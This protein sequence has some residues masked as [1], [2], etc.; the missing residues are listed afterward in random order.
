MKMMKNISILTGAFVMAL[1][2]NSSFAAD[3]P[4]KQMK[5]AIVNVQEVLQKSP[6]VTALSKKLESEFK[7][8]QT[9]INDEQKS[10]QDS[11]EKIKKDAATMSQK[12]KDAVEKKMK[13]QK[14]ELV[15]QYVNYQQDL[16]KEQQ[17]AMQG[18]LKDLNGIVTSIAKDKSYSLVLDAQAVIF[19]ADGADITKDVADQFNKNKS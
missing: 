12:D 10:Y 8:R 7:S 14:D 9:K 2:L 1:S 13:A 15:K 5:V 3:E 17:K 19:A 16:Q 18:I 11:L 4:A 6:R